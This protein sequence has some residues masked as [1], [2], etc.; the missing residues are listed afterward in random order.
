[1]NSN[2]NSRLLAE[3]QAQLLETVSTFRSEITAG[4]PA[5]RDA[6]YEIEEI[7]AQLAAGD[8]HPLR[9]QEGGSHY[10]H[11]AYQPA[12]CMHEVGMPPL[13]AAAF[14]YICRHRRKGGAG[15]IRKA[16]HY[17]LL[18]RELAAGEGP[19]VYNAFEIIDFLEVNRAQDGTPDGLTPS[20]EEAILDLATFMIDPGNDLA[21]ASAIR[22][23]RQL[24]REYPGGLN[25]GED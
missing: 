23:L 25:R 8:S 4:R 3:A 22:S 18:H 19:R 7:V 6:K 2:E 5:S 1:M 20:D 12:V 13:I 15:D 24:A 17:V 11:L 10:Q 14:K 9:Y 21:C 16:I